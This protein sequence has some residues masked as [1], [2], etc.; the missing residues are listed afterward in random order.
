MKTIVIGDVHGRDQWIVMKK[1]VEGIVQIQVDAPD[2]REY[3]SIEDGV[4]IVKKFKS[5]DDEK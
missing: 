1:H 5:S 2:S 4:A 3:L